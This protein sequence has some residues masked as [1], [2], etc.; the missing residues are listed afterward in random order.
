MT[1]FSMFWDTDGTG[2]GL[3]PY[4]DDNWQ[5]LISM[6]FQRN[7]T[8]EGVVAGYRN[9]LAVTGVA[10]PLSVNTGGAVVY[11]R[12][13]WSTAS[14][15]VIVATPVVGTTGGYVAVRRDWAAQTVRLV[16]VRNTDG[17]IAI[18]TATQVAGTTWDVI[19]ATFTI[20]TLGAITLTDARDY[21]HFN[22]ALVTRRQ[23][24]S[25]TNWDVDGTT[26][27]IPGSA[28]IQTGQVKITIPAG[29]GNIARET[30]ITYPQGY[31]YTPWLGVSTGDLGSSTAQTS[32]AVIAVDGANPTTKAL[33]RATRRDITSTGADEDV[34]CNWIAIG[35]PL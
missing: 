6:L 13:Y 16:A 34:Y 12:P 17:L 14:E 24:G 33:I 22:T 5:D 20:T 28:V 26:N 32:R 15:N 2:D 29:G 19:I 35:S 10:S 3:L 1:Q 9:E 30:T 18:P 25:A 21:C 4:S 11:G 23:G 31:K 27:Y 7:T 8:T